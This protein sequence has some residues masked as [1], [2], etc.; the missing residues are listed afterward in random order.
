M[1]Q[2]VRLVMADLQVILVG[3]QAMQVMLVITEQEELVVQLVLQAIQVLLLV[4]LVILVIMEQAEQVV[5][6]A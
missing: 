2:Q 1:V 3:H 6:L 4:M 5:M